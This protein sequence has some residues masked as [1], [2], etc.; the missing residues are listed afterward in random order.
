MKIFW[1]LEAE[2]RKNLLMLFTASL[3][4]WSSVAS[5]LPTMSPY[6]E[7]MGGTKQQVGLVISSFSIGIILFRTI[8]GRLADKHGRK[9]V[10][11]IGVSIGAIAPLCY[12]LV[13]SIGMLMLIRGFHG[14]SLAAF[15]TGYLALVT[16]LSPVDKRGELLSYMN[17]ATPIGLGVG[18]ALGGFLQ[19]LVGYTA[20]FVAISALSWLSW[21]FVSQVREQRMVQVVAPEAKKAAAIP[22]WQLV[23][24]PRMRIPALVLLLVGLSFGGLITFVPLFIRETGVNLNP[25]LYFTTAAIASFN[26]RL[27]TGPASDRYGRGIFITGSLISFGLAMLVLSQAQTPQVFL[28]AGVMQGI[29][30]GTILSIMI[31]LLSDRSWSTERGI[32]YSIGLSGFDLGGAISPPIFGLL[33]D[34]LDYQGIFYLASILSFL[35]LITFLT[36]SSK[37]LS[38]SLRFAIGREPDAYAVERR[39]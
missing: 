13:D 3:L 15:T 11:L 35:A 16:D 23:S 33:A 32:V 19:A 2:R 10:L 36:Q 39:C 12:L 38:H 26:L 7:D 22:L 14:I 27:L 20:L 29:G 9:L 30:T 18:P 5:M 34:W 6:A 31:A 24:S 17:L 8:I 21:L 1:E 25:G 28:L 37:N 4:F